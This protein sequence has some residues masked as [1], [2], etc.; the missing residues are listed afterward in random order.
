MP[1]RFSVATTYNTK[2]NRERVQMYKC[3]NESTLSNYWQ[4]VGSQTTAFHCESIE[5]AGTND[6]R[7]IAAKFRPADQLR[8]KL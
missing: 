8:R 2:K 5:Q 4:S 6:Y 7:T 3:T 1:F